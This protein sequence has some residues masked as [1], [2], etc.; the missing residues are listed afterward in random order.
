[1]KW[2]WPRLIV[3]VIIMVY[4]S[5]AIHEGVHYIVAKQSNETISEVCLLGD[6]TDEQGVHYQGWV[7]IKEFKN[8]TDYYT[9]QMRKLQNY[10]EFLACAVQVVFI[11]ISFLWLGWDTIRELPR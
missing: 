1:M 7:T 11:I 9:L 6:G 10:D 2:Q 3:L 5:V 8:S 4:F